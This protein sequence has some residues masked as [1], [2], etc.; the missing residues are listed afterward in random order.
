MLLILMLGACVQPSTDTNRSSED[1][2]PNAAKPDAPMNCLVIVLD[3]FHATKS[4]LYGYPEKTTPHIDQWAE[5][6]VVFEDM[7]SQYTSTSGSTWSY[8]N[9]Q[10]PYRIEK[11]AANRPQDVPLASLF[12]AAGYRCGGFSDNPFINRSLRMDRGFTHFEYYKYDKSV[13]LLKNAQES[14]PDPE[15]FERPRNEIS[16]LLTTQLR[17][18]VV[19]DESEP[20]FAYLHTLRPHNPY[21]PEEPWLNKFTDTSVVPGDQEPQDYLIELE[22]KFWVDNY[23]QRDVSDP[24]QLRLMHDTYLSNILYTDHLV[25]SLLKSLQEEGQLD[26]TLVIIMSD[27]G[28]AFG[29]HNNSNHG[30]TPYRELNHVPFIVIPPTHM[31]IDPR[32]VEESVELVD[33]LPTLTELFELDDPIE[34]DGQ[35]L[36]PLLRGHEGYQKEFRY[37]QSRWQIAVFDKTQK[38][39]LSLNTTEASPIRTP[40]QYDLA[41]DPFEKENVFGPNE[42]DTTLLGLARGYIARQNGT[43]LPEEPNLS[44]EELEI[45]KSLGYVD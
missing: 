7:V 1:L 38:L 17:D 19:N 33:L 35:S 2:R 9:G 5:K 14:S 22:N 11:F 21:P 16:E 23:M 26:N 4:S 42:N 18:W 24:E 12:N 41:A 43:P 25:D 37:S 44:L 34:R 45:L 30:G 39:I 31:N 36:I 15:D 20:W 29:E 8:L 3:A 6:G 10:Y 40:E 13:L 32:R 28:E 27:H